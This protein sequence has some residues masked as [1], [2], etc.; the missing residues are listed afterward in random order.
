MWNNKTS[1]EEIIKDLK[2]VI[3]ET[4]PLGVRFPITTLVNHQPIEYPHILKLNKQP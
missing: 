3:Q 4:Q 1:S 2:K